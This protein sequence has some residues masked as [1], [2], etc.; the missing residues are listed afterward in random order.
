MPHRQKAK[1][2]SKLRVLL[3]QIRNDSVTRLEELTSFASFSGL[4]EQQISILNVFDRPHFEPEVVDPFDAV[5]V[6]GSSDASVLEPIDYPFV[7]DAEALLRYCIKIGKPTFCSCFGHQLAVTALGGT[8]I[9]DESDYEMG[10]LPISLTDTAKDDPLFHDTPNPFMAVSVHRERAPQIPEGCTLLAETEVCSH[11]FKVDGAPFW[12]TQF[13]PEVDRK[14]LV[15]RLTLYAHKYTK[16]DGHLQQVLQSAVETPESNHL[17]KKFIDRVVMAA[18][19]S[20]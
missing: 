14:V 1:P 3:L 6:G 9:R 18:S 19:R 13:H 17:L 16:G 8:V 10:T 4:E 15:E 7:P 5:F 11:S 12:T 20:E 2:K